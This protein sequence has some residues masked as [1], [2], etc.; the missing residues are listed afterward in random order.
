[1]IH[2]REQYIFTLKI[3]PKEKGIHILRHMGEGKALAAVVEF[4]GLK[5]GILDAGK[6]MRE[7]IEDDEAYW[8]NDEKTPFHPDIQ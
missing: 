2:S 4:K 1:M 6:M 5:Q 7:A 8:Y 3:F